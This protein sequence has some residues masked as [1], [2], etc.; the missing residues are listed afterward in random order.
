MI[1][2]VPALN[3]KSAP[4]FKFEMELIKPY[5]FRDA[6]GFKDYKPSVKSTPFDVNK[7]CVY[8]QDDGLGNLM[9]IIDDATN[10]QVSNPNVG[11]VDYTT[12]LIKLNDIIVEA[13]DGSS[14]K[15]MICPKKS[16][17]VSPKGRVLIIRDTDVQVNMALE[18]IPGG[19]TTSSS[20]AIGTLTT[21]NY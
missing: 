12:G 7:I 21:S 18:E 9:T 1:D 15:I 3:I 5:P 14:V 13:F 10:P 4:S 19:A 6:N 17:I 8:I 16:D 20:S 2:W 11:S